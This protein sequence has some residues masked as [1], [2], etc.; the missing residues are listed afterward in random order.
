MFGYLGLARLTD[1]TFVFF[2]VSWLLTRHIG[3][4]AVLWSV[5][6][7][8][9]ELPYAWGPAQGV[10]NTQRVVWTFAAL[11]AAIQAMS[12]MWFYLAIK[13]AYKVVNGQPAE[14]TRS[15]DEK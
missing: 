15:D 11:L 10:Y 12:C 6:Y 5:V 4:N 9:P 8:L 2:L 7:R 3:Y 1:A 14:D 13:V